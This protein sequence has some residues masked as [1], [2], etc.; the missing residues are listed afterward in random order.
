MSDSPAQAEGLIG[1]NAILQLLPV[2]DRLGGTER[3]S[4]MLARAGIFHLPDGTRMIPET[5]A[6]RLHRQLR[7]EEPAMAPTLARE[8]GTRTAN[9]ILQHRIPA[10]AQWVL[11]ALPAGPAAA[12]LS[13]AIAKHAWTFVGSGTLTVRG[14]WTYSIARNP[15][16]AGETSETCLCDWHAGVFSRLY[17]ELVCVSA[18]CHET[19]CCAQSTGGAC[20]FEISR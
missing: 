8:A 5:E 9:Y 13:R 20:L 17:Q 1:P 12:L 4:Q 15:L 10:P 7:I 18:T 14:A 19:R 2:L 6:A 16:V 3:R 11:R